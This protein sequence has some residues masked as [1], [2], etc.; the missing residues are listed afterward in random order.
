MAEIRVFSPDTL[1]FSAFVALQK[2]AFAQIIGATGTDYL[3]SE[4][5]YRWK[6]GAPAGQ[7]RIAL[8]L[9]DGEPIAANSMYALRASGDGESARAWQSCDTATHPRGRGRGYFLKCL[10]ALKETLVEDELFIGFPNNNSTHGFG[11]FGCEFHGNVTTFARVL[12]G[13]SISAFPA[14]APIERFDA[15]Q[16]EFARALE[17]AGSTQLERGAAY[18]NWRYRAHPFHQYECFEWREAGRRQG[19]LVM[20]RADLSGRRLAIALELLANEP[21]VERGLLAF[22][23]AWA[24]AQGV[25]YT[26]VLNNTLPK[27]R[28]LSMAYIPVPMWALPKRQ[29]LM[30]FARGP[31]AERLW[32]KPWR[33]Q[34]GDWD[35]F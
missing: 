31:V 19:L 8:V 16:D 25:R 35:G 2:T 15:S 26:M 7:G 6:Y 1:D 32:S 21:A 4:P 11:K 12:P 10:Q 23:A 29:V 24:R 14:V 3:F 28:G 22:A 20:R 17:R 18:M 27:A 30:G 5:Y 9:E 33:V 13:R 34:I